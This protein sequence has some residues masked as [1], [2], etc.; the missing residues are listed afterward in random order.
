[1]NLDSINVTLPNYFEKLGGY[2]IYD[3]FVKAY[4]VEG[5]PILATYLAEVGFCEQPNISFQ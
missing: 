1:V 4:P 5:L 3:F 2:K